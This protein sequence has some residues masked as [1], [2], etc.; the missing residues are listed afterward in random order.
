MEKIK[1]SL[2]EKLGGEKR[3]SRRGFLKTIAAVGAGLA[4]GNKTEALGKFGDIYERDMEADWKEG[5][6]EF[7]KAALEG[8]SEVKSFYV[9]DGSGNGKWIK[10]DKLQ[11]AEELVVFEE[12][13]LREL[14]EMGAKEVR[15]IHTH[16]LNS[17]VSGNLLSEEEAEK[18]RSGKSSPPIMPPSFVAGGEMQ[19]DIFAM[20]NLGRIAKNNNLKIKNFVLDPSGVWE[21]G[22]AKEEKPPEFEEAEKIYL[23]ERGDLLKMLFSNE[24]V[25][26]TR[27]YE[28]YEKDPSNPRYALENLEYSERGKI[29]E[30]AKFL[31]MK[32]NVRQ[33]EFLIKYAP[34]FEFDQDLIIDMIKK[35]VKQKLTE[36]DLDLIIKH[37]KNNGVDLKYQPM[38]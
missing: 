16:P 28:I 9:I 30:E 34:A 35:S 7:R 13:F 36:E 18:I 27:A 21:Y 8:E 31:V 4:L 24:S 1:F 29:D 12:D 26:R 33:E 5:I 19:G 22:Q 14:S 6:K 20:M 17:F 38:S 25:K 10:P 2:N 23:E 11:E 32:I 15:S 3:M 37:Y